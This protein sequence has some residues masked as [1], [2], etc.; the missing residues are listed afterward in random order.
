MQVQASHRQSTD[1]TWYIKE[2]D[3]KMQLWINEN[4]IYFSSYIDNET[5][6]WT[7]TFFY[8]S[9]EIAR[10][11]WDFGKTRFFKNG[12]TGKPRTGGS[13]EDVQK[14]VVDLGKTVSILE[15]QLAQL[16]GSENLWTLE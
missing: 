7:T 16:E 12:G 10:G 13:C 6:L 14:K 15:S 8:K 4:D 1:P 9:K 3:W 5:Q 11:V 2:S